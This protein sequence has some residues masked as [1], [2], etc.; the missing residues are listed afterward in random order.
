MNHD[1][2]L[3]V[4]L[5]PNLWNSTALGPLMHGGAESS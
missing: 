1:V 2:L 4:N 3:Y 5:A